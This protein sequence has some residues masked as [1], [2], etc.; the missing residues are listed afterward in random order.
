MTHISM[1]SIILGMIHSI[2]HIGDMRDV[3]MIHIMDI[4]ITTTIVILIIILIMAV[5]RIIQN[6][7]GVIII[8]AM[9]MSVAISIVRHVWLLMWLRLIG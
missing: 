8:G 5:V 9:K 7:I 4:I 1:D 3:T 2:L 6:Q